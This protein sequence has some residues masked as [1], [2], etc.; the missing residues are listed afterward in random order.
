MLASRVK[1]RPRPLALVA[2]GSI[3]FA[4]SDFT[5]SS[6][7]GTPGTAEVR[8]DDSGRDGGQSVTNCI[9]S[10]RILTCVPLPLDKSETTFTAKHWDKDECC[11]HDAGALWSSLGNSGPY[12]P[13]TKEVSGYDEENECYYHYYT[14]AKYEIDNETTV[15]YDMYDSAAPTTC[16][17]SGSFY[18][19]CQ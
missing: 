9:V 12:A 2:A 18:I 19:D 17:Q 4:I 15:L 5:G 13:M 8:D 6:G 1:P 3:A 11:A 16:K 14:S 10:A 7:S